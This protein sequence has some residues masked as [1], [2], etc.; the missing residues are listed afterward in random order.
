MQ[1]EHCQ[2]DLT[3]SRISVG[4]LCDDER[5]A[6]AQKSS[7]ALGGDRRGSEAAGDHR[8]GSG[9]PPLLVCEVFRPTMMNADPLIQIE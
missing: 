7:R 2:T 9:P 4:M 8:I 6:N 5:S 1:A 3:P